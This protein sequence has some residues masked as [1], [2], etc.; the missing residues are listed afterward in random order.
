MRRLLP[1]AAMV[2]LVVAAPAR[3]DV[4]GPPAGKVLSGLS[5]STSTAS[6]SSQVGKRP[7]VFGFFTQWWGNNQFIFDSARASHSRLMLHI[8]TNHGYGEPEKVTPLGI[9]RGVG[10]SYLLSLNRKIADYGE[11]VYIRLMAEM[12][13]TNNAYCAFNR[14]GSPRNAAHRTKA[15]KNAWRR[16]ALILRGGPVSAIGQKT[17]AL[18]LPPVRGPD[19]GDELPEPQV[20][21]LWVPQT[22]G[23]PA[24]ARNSAAAYWPGAGYVD[25]V[26]TDF[27]SKFPNFSK[28]ETFYREFK[29]PFVFG[30]W[31]LWGGDNPAFVSEL[32]HFVNTHKRVRMMLY[33]LGN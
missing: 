27:Y 15:F 33:N 22:E 28:L 20:A 16:S 23:S 1:V 18:D 12:N 30:E 9:A 25:W 29:Q 13:Q 26:G 32:F 21:M 5:G 17:K 31:A 4:F 3:A 2:C 11:P 7:A 6:F 24:I 19:A 14:N 10:D 8:S